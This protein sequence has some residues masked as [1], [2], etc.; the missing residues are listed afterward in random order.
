MVGG[1]KQLVDGLL[2]HRVYAMYLYDREGTVQVLKVKRLR[3]WSS[4]QGTTLSLSLNQCA[5]QKKKIFFF[6]FATAVHGTLKW[7][8]S[9][10]DLSI[11][12][13]CSVAILRGIEEVCQLSIERKKACRDGM[14]L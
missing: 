9:V 11:L 8:G 5:T 1:D 4:R 12:L 3:S 6:P 7:F 14:R 13:L 2:I 10:A